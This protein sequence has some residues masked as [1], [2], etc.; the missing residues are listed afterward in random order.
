MIL[1]GLLVFPIA[2]RYI[3]SNITME[4]PGAMLSRPNS[5]PPGPISLAAKACPPFS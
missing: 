5:K 3:H 4:E 2:D 1:N